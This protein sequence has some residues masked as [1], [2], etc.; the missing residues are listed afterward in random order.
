MITK[1]Y[2]SKASQCVTMQLERSAPPPRSEAG[3]AGSDVDAMDYLIG[4]DAGTTNEKVILFDTEGRTLAQSIRPSPLTVGPK[5]SAVYDAGRVWGQVCDMLREVTASV[6]KEI[7][8]QIAGIA[9]TGMA[10]AGVPLSKEGE[11]LYPFISW[12]DPRTLPYQAWWERT[13]PAGWVEE[14]TGLRVQHIFSVNKIMWLRDNLQ[15]VYGKMRA[16]ACMEDYLAFQLTG[17]LKMDTTIACRTMLLDLRTKQWSR[18]IADVAGISLSLLPELTAPGSPVGQVTDEASR[19]TG[20]RAGT[21]VFAGGHDHICGALACGILD[22]SAVLDSSGTAE[23]VL[24]VTPDLDRAA[25]LGRTGYN[26]GP[27]AAP[28]LYYTAGGIPASGAAMDWWAKQFPAAA[29]DDRT[30]GA[31]GLLFLPHL[32]GSSSPHRDPASRGAFLGIRPY[33]TAADFSQAVCEGLCFEFLQALRCLRG[34]AQPQKIVAIGGGTKNGQWMRTKANVTGLPIEIPAIQESTALG[35]ALLAGIGAGIYRSP[36]DAAKRVYRTGG[37]VEPD[38]EVRET[39]ER[40]YSVYE[41]LYPAL[42]PISLQ[43][44]ETEEKEAST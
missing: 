28:G 30:A 9:I 5:G 35:A 33:H 1:R 10:E 39:Y 15:E 42:L 38:P 32:R 25:S 12:Y 11:A 44:E 37:R 4:I 26:V 7:T 24:A 8:G 43:L 13:V 34:T 23:E 40:L 36:A 3:Y 22:T 17:A 16:W 31:K 6:G 14:I 19:L 41:T 20:L 29:D 21:P 18:E 27:H 2:F